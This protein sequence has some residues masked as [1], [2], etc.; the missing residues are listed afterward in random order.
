[1]QERQEEA[2]AATDLSPENR[3][4]REGAPATCRTE[5]WG[6]RAGAGGK[7][8]EVTT[9]KG[10]IFM[11]E[12]EGGGRGEAA[13]GE[14]VKVAEKLEGEE[15]LELGAEAPEGL[16]PLN[17]VAQVWTLWKPSSGE[18]EALST[19]ADRAYLWLERSCTWS[20]GAASSRIFLAL[21]HC[22][23]ERL[24]ATITKT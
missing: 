11:E 7:A 14:W 24:E 17:L 2:S 4:C 13:V 10:A 8:E 1:M 22:L 16:G 18:Q 5:G 3:P 9:E 23:P 15:K 19:Q 6:A 21:G 20:Q 12:A